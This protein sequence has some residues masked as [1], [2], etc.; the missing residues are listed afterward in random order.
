L[1]ETVEM[2]VVDDKQVQSSIYKFIRSMASE[3]THIIRF[4]EESTNIFEYFDIEKQIQ[5]ALERKVPLKS[6]GS[7]IV[8]TTEA[9]TVVDVNTGKFI[10][11]SSLEETIFKTNM[12]AA[13]EIARQLCLRNIG[14]LIVIDFIDMATSSN[15]QK[16]FKFF[17]K[18]LKERDKFQSVV[19]RIS[20]FGIVQM[21]R[22][23]SGRTLMQQLMQQ[24][25][26]CYS[27][28]FVKSVETRAYEL[29]RTL[30]KELIGMDA[31]EVTI[32]LNPDLFNHISTV[33]YEA[34]LFIEKA[35]KGKIILATDPTLMVGEY[36]IQKT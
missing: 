9:M 23:R 24:C 25:P 13:Q 1:D 26:C 11:K 20:E 16:L 31:K 15:R 29:F 35:I 34:V 27:L 28:G 36:R 33:E 22:K 14:G 8:E 7:L 4:Y 30:Q 32:F 10:G 5:E 2:I 6:G 3:F 21:T 18:T 17:E 12:E 19:L